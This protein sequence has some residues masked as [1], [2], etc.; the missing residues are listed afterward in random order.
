M[1]LS[2]NFIICVISRLVLIQFF[3]PLLWV[4]LLYFFAC[5]ITFDW[6]SNIVNY[7]CRVHLDQK[8]KSYKL[9]YSFKYKISQLVLLTFNRIKRSQSENE[10]TTF[11]LNVIQPEVNKIQQAGQIQPKAC[12]CTVWGLRLV[13]TFLK[14]C[15]RKK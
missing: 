15:E 13:F 8:Q 12:F 6:T 1:F 10:R 3:F 14:S 5:L 11:W 4:I 7:T 2:T 9:S